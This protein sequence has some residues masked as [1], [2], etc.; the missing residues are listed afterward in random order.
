MKHLLIIGARLF[1]RE[2][3]NLAINSIGFGD[4]FDIKGFLDDNPNALD[5]FNNYPAILSSVEEY[6][7]VT[8][9]VFICALSSPIYKK[10]YTDI[11]KEKKGYFINIIHKTAI[12]DMNTI[13]GVGCMICGYT[14]VSCDIRIGNFVTIQPNSII[15]HD[16]IIGDYCHLNCFSFMGGGAVLEDM[17]TLQT[18]AK[19][20]PF[21]KVGAGS[22]VGAGSI[23]LNKVKPGVTVFGNPAT[24]LKF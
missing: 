24:V 5:G 9:D 14:Y 18:S 13:I 22:T 23:V 16:S 19:V 12:I 8:N 10:K 20:M 21:K 4:E 1:G 7:I 6:E 11:I 2:V 17:V 3:Y 15:G